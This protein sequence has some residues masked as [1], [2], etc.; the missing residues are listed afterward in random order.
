[1]ALD[2][3]SDDNVWNR[4]IGGD[5]SGFLFRSRS[6]SVHCPLR[7]PMKATWQVVFISAAGAASLISASRAS[8]A[9]QVALALFYASAAFLL[10][11]VLWTSGRSR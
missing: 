6:A 8:Q 10:A 7:R 2:A 3:Q 5:F 9:H 11:I 1:M 4:Q